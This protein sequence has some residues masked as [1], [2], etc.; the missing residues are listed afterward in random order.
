MIFYGAALFG[1]AALLLLMTAIRGL[2]LQ[3]LS[4]IAF[5]ALSGYAFLS[6]L[7]C[8]SLVEQ[9][10]GENYL[11]GA[12]VYIIGSL[13]LL[14][15]TKIF[16]TWLGTSNFPMPNW[17]KYE[18][19]QHSSYALGLGLAS[20]AL[21][22]WTRTDL[23]STWNE[24]RSE[25]GPLTVLAI[26]F[27]LL[28]CPGIVSATLSKRPFIA[29]VLLMLCGISFA[30]VGSRAA[31]LCALVFAFWL[32]LVR[33]KGA[34]QQLKIFV[35]TAIIGFA[36][37]VF[38]R[39]VRGVGLVG[40]LQ[41]LN[42]GDLFSTLFGGE[43]N[44]DISGGEAAIPKYLLFSTHVNSVRD[45]GFMTSIQRLALLPIP[46][47]EGW[48]DKPVDV[49]YLFWEAAYK[50]GMFADAEG[51]EILFYS[52]VSGSLGSLHPTVFGE[53]YLTGG[54]ISLFISTI[55]LGAVLSYIDYAMRRMNRLTSL[56]LCGPILVGY[57]FVARGNSVIG[58]GYFFY[59]GILFTLL[60][61]SV[62]RLMYFV[63]IG[64]KQKFMRNQKNNICNGANQ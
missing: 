51:Q 20:L 17:T 59:L 30:M 42:D 5:V 7:T 23:L 12:T 50:A 27:L 11:Y 40:L 46:R 38:L 19:R 35:F 10:G 61:Y 57:L 45:F 34:G 24:A 25:S 64:N 62:N 3:N 37:H 49:T 56:A 9:F 4:S 31:L 52:Y 18:F 39:Q 21:F 2:H 41:A 33:A 14:V 29:L 55:I 58:L 8:N 53:Y 13:I 6:I 22:A 1:I 26:L 48:F 15:S 47:I 16:T 28:A 32:V 44:T 54:W 43:I 63:K 36:I 60:R